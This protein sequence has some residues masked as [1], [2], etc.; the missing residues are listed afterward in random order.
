MKMCLLYCHITFSKAG[1]MGGRK[2]RRNLMQRNLPSYHSPS[3][4]ERHNREKRE[5][6]D[7]ENEIDEKNGK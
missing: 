7:D 4:I 6:T 1:P 2:I 3:L 5:A